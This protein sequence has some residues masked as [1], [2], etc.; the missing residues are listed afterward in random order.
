M[1]VNLLILIFE[2]FKKNIYIYIYVSVILPQC[3]AK[4]KERFYAQ[5]MGRSEPDLR[6]AARSQPSL[7]RQTLD[8]GSQTDVSGEVSQDQVKSWVRL[9]AS[10]NT[11]VVT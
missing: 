4:L 11:L 7:S 6:N 1:Y 9:L 8:A 10:S 3:L 2:W 5:N